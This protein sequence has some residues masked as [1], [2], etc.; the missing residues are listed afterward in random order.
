MT[1][2]AGEDG[3]RTA[4]PLDISPDILTG[5]REGAPVHALDGETMGTR[6]S[7]KAL[8]P[9][10]VAPATIAALL[11]ARLDT[12]IDQLSHWERDSAITRFNR[13]EAG[14]WHTLE[15]DF[16][17]VMATALDLAARSE[18]TFDPAI[19]VLVNLHGFGPRPAPH[20]PPSRD[21]IADALA[22]SGWARL[23]W[24]TQTS[25]LRQPGGLHLDFSG[26]AKGYGVDALAR[27]LEEAGLRHFLVE[28]GGEFAGRGLRPDGDPWWVELETPPPALLHGIAPLRLALCGQAVATSGDYVR[29]CHTIDPRDGQPVHHVLALSVIDATTMR[30]DGWAT[31]LGVLP[32]PEIEALATH[33]ALAVRALVRRREE[34]IEWISP[35]LARMME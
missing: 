20:Q 5:W 25:R 22:I 13:A 18:G 14:S 23:D 2:T 26:I 3:A 19:G 32:L 15:P 10:G 17:Q 31:A 35:A 11:H 27:T 8:L 6:W 33:E 34:I 1:D 30:A 9:E 28:I 7:L 4:V 12:L 29:G 16:A 24:D 21:A